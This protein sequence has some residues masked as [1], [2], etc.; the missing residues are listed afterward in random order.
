MHKWQP[1]WGMFNQACLAEA[2]SEVE[3]ANPDWHKALFA[4]DLEP[5]IATLPRNKRWWV[6]PGSRMP[7][8]QDS[9]NGAS[10]Y[11]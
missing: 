3:D 7:V 4:T 10:Q 11:L 9:D 1:N 5:Y 2:C 6:L 8:A